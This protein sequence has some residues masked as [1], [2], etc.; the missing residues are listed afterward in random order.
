MIQNTNKRDFG[1]GNEGIGSYN[2]LGG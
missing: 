1:A 2:M